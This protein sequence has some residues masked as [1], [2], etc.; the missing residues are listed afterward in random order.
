LCRCL[1]LS[2]S[3]SSSVTKVYCSMRTNTRVKMFYYYFF[4]Y[5]Y[6]N[7]DCSY[8]RSNVSRV[9]AVFPSAAAAV[10]AE[11]KSREV[12][13]YQSLQRRP[14]TESV[15]Q[16][17]PNGGFCVKRCVIFH[18]YNIYK[19][20]TPACYSDTCAFKSCNGKEIIRL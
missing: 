14:Q 20:Y 11:L 1:T 8:P 17:K 4:Y 18:I 6:L 2:S 5:Y 9:V 16:L 7:G 15:E 3:S 19:T 13:V 10:R 12:R